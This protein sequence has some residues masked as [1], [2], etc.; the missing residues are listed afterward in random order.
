MKTRIL[1]AA[2]ALLWSS[3]A[4]FAANSQTTQFN[5]SSDVIANCTISALD[6]NFGN[7]DPVVANKTANRD[8]TTSVNVLCTKGASG[9]TVGLDLGG[10]GSGSSRFML[11]GVSG[12][13]LQYELYSDAA[14]SAVWG[15]SGSG[16]VALAT[17]GPIGA[18][19]GVTN[20]IYGR[21]PSGQDKSVGHY[22]DVV[23]ATVNF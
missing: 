2:V 18:G 16:L 9:V 10:H 22:T 8:V 17:F 7:Y 12:D 23:T 15:N 4:A 14:R 19:A 20:T 6:L 11:D 21:I 13:T 5:V 3:G 1:F